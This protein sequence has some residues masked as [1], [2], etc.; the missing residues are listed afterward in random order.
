MSGD[1]AST[2]VRALVEPGSPE[3]ASKASNKFMD[4]EPRDQCR[5]SMGSTAV[6]GFPLAFGCT[7]ASGLGDGHGHSLQGM[8]SQ[9]AQRQA[10]SRRK[11]LGSRP[12]KHGVLASEGMLSTGGLMLNGNLFEWHHPAHGSS[13]DL[14]ISSNKKHTVATPSRVLGFRF[15][16]Q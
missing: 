13:C 15:P 7:V 6:R 9:V 8:R 2:T 10:T 16:A 1:C 14:G 3:S 5:C 12:P 11:S 4:L